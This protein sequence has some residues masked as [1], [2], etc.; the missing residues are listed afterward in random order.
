MPDP[1]PRP[2][3]QASVELVAVVP[4]ALLAALA[5]GQLALAG[6][7]LWSAAEAARAGARAEL[8]G[9]DAAD[10]ARSA[11]PDWLERDADIGAGDPLSV[12]VEVPALLPGAPAIPVVAHAG[13]GEAPR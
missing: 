11:L 8:V 10:S 9:G 4:L 12:R 13:L 5:T 2:S 6:Y 7:G 1:P 3:G